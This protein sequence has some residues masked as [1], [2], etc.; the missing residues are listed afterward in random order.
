MHL[1]VMAVWPM[2]HNPR[3]IS[4][5][6]KFCELDGKS[7][8]RPRPAFWPLGWPTIRASASLHNRWNLW[9]GADRHHFEVPWPSRALGSGSRLQT[10]QRPL[11]RQ[12]QRGKVAGRSFINNYS[13]ACPSHN[14]VIHSA[15]HSLDCQTS[16]SGS[17]K[18]LRVYY[19]ACPAALAAQG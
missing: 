7:L 5:N 19:P 15:G 10:S 4:S 13:L 12:L 6:A 9:D 2:A 1:E 17:S 18:R 16:H 14:R 8:K 3:F 11:A